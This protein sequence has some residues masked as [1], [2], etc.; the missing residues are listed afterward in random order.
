MQL[1][2]KKPYDD[3]DSI[4]TKIT[5]THHLIKTPL[6]RYIAS[7]LWQLAHPEKQREYSRRWYHRNKHT[8]LTMAK[9]ADQ[10]QKQ[11]VLANQTT[12]PT[13]VELFKAIS[14]QSLSQS[15][16]TPSFKQL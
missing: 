10:I 8:R 4:E 16:T 6:N 14:K 7:K 15:D 3:M 13:L 2:I 12:R 5:S 1:T 11:E 9:P